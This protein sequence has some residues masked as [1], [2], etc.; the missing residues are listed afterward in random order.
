MTLIRLAVSASPEKASSR[1]S[2][3]T[4]HS[5]VSVL[6]LGLLKGI[7][8]QLRQGARRVLGEKQ[9]LHMG[10]A[11]HLFSPVGQALHGSGRG[12]P[13][14]VTAEGLLLP[15]PSAAAKR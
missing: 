4:T 15:R 5:W 10:T 7:T 2:A 8:E 3:R 11:H 14:A 13:L 9:M 12:L 6:W 1:V